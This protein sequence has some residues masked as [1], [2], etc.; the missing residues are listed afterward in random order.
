MVETLGKIAMVG[1]VIMFAA[2]M[3]FGA[4]MAGNGDMPWHHKKPRRKRKDEAEE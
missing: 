3:I 4:Y 2:M 1:I